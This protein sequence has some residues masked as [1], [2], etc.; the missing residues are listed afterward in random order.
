MYLG[1]FLLLWAINLVVPALV[2]NA[3][4]VPKRGVEAADK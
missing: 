3:T 2:S 4:H 1:L